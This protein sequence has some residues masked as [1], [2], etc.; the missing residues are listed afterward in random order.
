[1]TP[2]SGRS[3][4]GARRGCCRRGRCATRRPAPRVAGR[5]SGDE[6]A[7]EFGE[8]TGI[9]SAV[10]ECRQP[11]GAVGSDDHATRSPAEVPPARPRQNFRAVHQQDVHAGQVGGDGQCPAC[12]H[13][14]SAR[15][16]PGREVFEE[17]RFTG[18]LGAD[19][20]RAVTERGESREQLIPRSVM[21]PVPLPQHPVRGKGI[22]ARLQA[23][24]PGRL[25]RR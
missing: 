25:A 9:G 23:G 20:R 10:M 5:Q 11:A 21:E 12:L 18:A 13:A 4:R 7:Q 15:R 19:N 17:R 22:I 6:R 24:S 3:N 8:Q 14:Q 2:P 1:M 16:Q